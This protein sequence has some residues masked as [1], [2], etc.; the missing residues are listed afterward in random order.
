MRPGGGGGGGVG[1]HGGGERPDCPVPSL[2]H[3]P[4][5]TEGCLNLDPSHQPFLGF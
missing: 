2:L 3:P 5:L 1:V 4:P